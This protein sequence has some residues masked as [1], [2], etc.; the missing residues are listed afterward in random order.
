MRSAFA[1]RQRRENCLIPEKVA[2][3]SLPRDALEKRM[4]DKLSQMKKDRVQS[5]KKKKK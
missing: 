2:K 4:N 1:T 3:N 5:G